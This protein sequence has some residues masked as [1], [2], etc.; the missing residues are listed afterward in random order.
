MTGV[1]V[2]LKEHRHCFSGKHLLS[3]PPNAPHTQ[4][5]YITTAVHT[6]P[7]CLLQSGKQQPSRLCIIKKGQ[8][9]PVE[10]G[11]A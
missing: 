7:L 2:D 3:F 4:S 9:V 1:D 6:D 10:Q 8:V 5:S 11:K